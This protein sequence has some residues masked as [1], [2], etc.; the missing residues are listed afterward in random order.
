[1]RERKVGYVIEPVLI[2]RCDKNHVVK[3]PPVESYVMVLQP[4]TPTI[5]INGTSNIAREYEDFRE[6]VRVFTDIHIT[7]GTTSK[8][9]KVWRQ[10]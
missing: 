1:M 8:H 3:I 2:F 6:G 4:Q 7:V 10:G 5:E 9:E